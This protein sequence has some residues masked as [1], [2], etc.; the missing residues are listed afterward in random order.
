MLFLYARLPCLT[1]GTQILRLLSP[2]LVLNVTMPATMPPHFDE[3]ALTAACQTATGHTPLPFQVAATRVLHSR[4]DVILIAPTGAGKSLLFQLPLM[5]P[6]VSEQAMVV[7][8]TPLKALQ[9]EQAA[10]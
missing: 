7:V 5:V 9:V 8:I 10:K 6:G 4:K 2:L 1:Q 3:N